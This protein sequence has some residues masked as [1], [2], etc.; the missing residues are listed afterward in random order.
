MAGKKRQLIDILLRYQQ[1]IVMLVVILIAAGVM[2]LVKMPRDEYP[3]FKVRQGIIV[4]VYPGAT[5]E[6]VEA[7][8]TDKVEQYLYQYKSIKRSETY[9]VSRENVMIVY[10]EVSE[11]EKDPDAFWVKL[12][13]GLNELKAGLPSGLASLTADNDFGNTSALL[14][15]VRSDGKTY[16]ELEDCISE[17]ENDVRRVPSVSRVKRYGALKEEIAVY[18]DNARLARY[19][20]R[21]L[22]LAA[23]IIPQST[24][25]YA[26]ELDDGRLAR[27]LHIPASYKTENDLAEQ[28]VYADPAGTVVRLKDVARIVR[29]YGEAQ[30]YVRVNGKKCLVVSLEM[31]SG[32]NI[33]EF[34]REVGRVIADFQKTL[35]PDVQIDIISNIPNAVARSI[36]SFLKEFAVAVLAV[37]AV[38]LILLPA[39]VALAA[40]ATIPVTILSTLGLLWAFGLDLQTVSLA[41]LIIVLGLVVDDP[42]VIIDN[43]VEKLDG[44][45]DRRRA[46]TLSVKELFPSVFAAT[47]II[48]CCF[49]PLSFMMKGMAGDFVRSMPPTIITSLS[50]SLMAASLL[51]PIMC[52]HFIKRGV[53]H[54]QAGKRTAFLDGL[55][56]RYD[57]L[58]ERVFRKKALVI[59]VGALSLVV[60]LVV[61]ALVPS[62]TFP[63]IERNQFAVEVS[64][65][66]GSSLEATDAVMRDLEDRLMKDTRVKVV[67]SFVGTSSPRFNTLYAPRF[68]SPDIGQLVVL[69]DSNESTI[70]ILDEY[71]RTFAGRYPGA[72]VRWKQ[73][74]MVKFTEPIEVRISGDDI[75]DLKRTSARVQDILRGEKGV[76]QVRTD[77]R[78][79][80][81]GVDVDVRKDEANRL[82]YP[83]VMLS[84]S[85]MTGTKG[86]PAGT[87]WEGDY[88]LQVRLKFE[89]PDQP[90]PADLENL[91]VTSPLLG[92]SVPL[93]QLADL[94]PA[95]TEGDIVRRN[96]V[97]T[98]TVMAEVKR[99]VYA[100]QVMKKVKPLID[101]LEL[102][103]GVRID[104]GGELSSSV[105]FFTPFYYSL[106]ITI[107][108]IFLILMFEFRSLKKSLLIMIMM[109]LTIFGAALGILITGYPFSLTAFIGIIALFGIVVRNGI[110]YVQ[111]A[112]ELRRE[113]GCSPEEA[114]IAAGKRRMRPIFL[115]AMAAAVGVVPMILGGSSLWGPLG[116]AICFGLLFALVLSL[117][118][119]PVLYYLLHKNER[120]APPEGESS[121]E[122]EVA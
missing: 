94:R 2:A 96:G 72:E 14:L 86:F 9:S 46:A 95:W 88:P 80:V 71:S 103:K 51:T 54:G 40:A 93:R 36:A 33:V 49:V 74:E 79:P 23:A 13:H 100:S 78:Q 113:Q 28:I 81:Q 58:V 43:Y 68:P 7:E 22:T 61:L 107:L 111:Y 11:K 18:L 10:V 25:G 29:E 70:K 37:I 110:I 56:R 52:F 119:L 38:T 102:P 64:L 101:G 6:Q 19:G 83:G 48:I 84:L 109:P 89:G 60:G 32:N 99:G 4:G 69:T 98:L 92:S 20:I 26:G 31:Q 65:P 53:R 24:S 114:A 66:A 1:P 85:L 44:G 104:Y 35:P 16:R 77:F 122:G 105:E 108:L 45:F 42:I 116:S 90:G 21:P 50:A 120:L 87:V 55:Q 97:R 12:R 15:S 30:S 117:L 106:G 47:I 63:K 91:Y 57:Q 39:R 62:Q 17:L 41:S 112:D 8:V 27:P 75:P 82:G 73:L 67:T 118:L 34:G 5:S 3:E 76:S 121:T 115:T 59:A